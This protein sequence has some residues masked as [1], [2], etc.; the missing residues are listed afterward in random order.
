MASFV[1]P[2]KVVDRKSAF[3]G[4]QVHK[5]ELKIEKTTGKKKS[6]VNLILSEVNHTFLILDPK[7]LDTLSI[8]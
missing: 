1:D 2:C 3:S 6:K 5:M 7:L 4:F 8:P